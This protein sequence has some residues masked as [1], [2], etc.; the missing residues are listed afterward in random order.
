MVEDFV[1]EAMSMVEQAWY[2]FGEELMYSQAD[3]AMEFHASLY[4][5]MRQK[6]ETDKEIANMIID[7]VF[8]SVRGPAGSLGEMEYEG[9][10]GLLMWAARCEILT[11]ISM[12]YEL[13]GYYFD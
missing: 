12:S 7:Q 2:N 9:A 11:G 5:A 4:D 1:E 13:M 10:P 3:A 6:W 8:S